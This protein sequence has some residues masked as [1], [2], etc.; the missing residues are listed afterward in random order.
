MAFEQTK[1]VSNGDVIGSLESIERMEVLKNTDI[2]EIM[3]K[4]SL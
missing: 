4:E 1:E 3:S 2:T